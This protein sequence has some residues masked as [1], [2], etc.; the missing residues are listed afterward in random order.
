MYL[1]SAVLVQ[2]VRHVAAESLYDSRAMR[3]FVDIAL[4]C[5]LVP[6]ERTACK[7]HHLLGEPLRLE[8]KRRGKQKFTAKN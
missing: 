4:G 7:F 8:Q 1:F 6:D 2:P 3:Y 5:E